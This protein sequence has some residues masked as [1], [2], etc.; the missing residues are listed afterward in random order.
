MKQIYKTA[1][2][3]Y[4]QLYKHL[5]LLTTVCA[6]F[7]LVG[8]PLYAGAPEKLTEAPQITVTQLTNTTST[9]NRTVQ[10]TISAGTGISSAALYYRLDGGAWNTAAVSVSGNTYNFTL[11][12]QPAGT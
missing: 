7:M 12:G 5:F 8:Q 9:S 6:T 1:H 4:F 11:V 2:R 3:G 10:S